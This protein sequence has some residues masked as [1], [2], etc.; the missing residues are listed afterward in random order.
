MLPTTCACRL[1]ILLTQNGHINSITPAMKLTLCVAVR[2]LVC[3]ALLFNDDTHPLRSTYSSHVLKF[4]A[5]AALGEKAM[6][7]PPILLSFEFN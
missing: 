4:F 2:L 1:L 6:D 7:G 3:T 5:L